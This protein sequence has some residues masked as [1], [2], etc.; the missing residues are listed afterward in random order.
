MKFMKQIGDGELT[1][2][3]GKVIGKIEDSEKTEPGD[4]SSEFLNEL[5]SPHWASDFK[6]EKGGSSYVFF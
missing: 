5:S 4:W 1:I 2:E 3:S 6:E